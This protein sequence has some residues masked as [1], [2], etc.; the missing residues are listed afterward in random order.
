MAPEDRAADQ[1]HRY[2]RPTL[3]LFVPQCAFHLDLTHTALLFHLHGYLHGSRLVVQHASCLLQLYRRQQAHECRHHRCQCIP[4]SKKAASMNQSHQAQNLHST[5][6]LQS[7]PLCL[8]CLRE[9]SSSQDTAAVSAALLPRLCR[10]RHTSAA[11]GYYGAAAQGVSISYCER[12]RMH[13]VPRACNICP[14]TSC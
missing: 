11:S 6:F 10:Q 5:D 1:R 13:A 9:I 2:A 8:V 12:Q 7:L 4:E 14:A 3:L